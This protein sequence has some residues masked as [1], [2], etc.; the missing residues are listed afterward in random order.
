LTVLII[1]DSN[2]VT[3]YDISKPVSVLPS[4]NQILSDLTQSILC[5]FACSE[6]LLQINS[7]NL[8]LIALNLISLVRTFNMENFNNLSSQ[9]NTQN[10]NKQSEFLEFL[11]DKLNEIIISD[12]SS[13]KVMGSCLSE[14]TRQSDFV[15]SKIAVIIIKT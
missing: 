5:N 8:N 9:L 1:D 2:G 3:V 4:S 10:I 11:L 13:M 6:Q 12:M 15:S 14:L 7:G